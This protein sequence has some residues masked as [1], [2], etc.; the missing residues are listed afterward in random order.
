MSR[1]RKTLPL[2]NT[3]GIRH[4]PRAA[5]FEKLHTDL[6]SELAPDGALEKHI[7]A[8]LTR[9]VWRKQNLAIFRVAELARD[10]YFAIRNEHCGKPEP[11][12]LLDFT[13]V[14]PEAAKAAEAQAREELG[15]TYELAN[16][17]EVATVDQMLRGRGDRQMF[18]AVAV[19]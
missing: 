4:D 3:V 10:R 2:S 19:S 7:V 16:M 6:I 8:T 5:A 1:T 11:T 12:Y 15:D 18:E 14:D 9:V 17:G 13:P